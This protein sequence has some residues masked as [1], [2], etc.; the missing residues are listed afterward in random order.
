M[1]D[2]VNISANN[3]ANIPPRMERPQFLIF[4]S[5]LRLIFHD[6][7]IKKCQISHLECIHELFELLSFNI[8][9][10]KFKRTLFRDVSIRRIRVLYS[11]TLG[12]FLIEHQYIFG[13]DN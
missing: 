1:F 11:L 4:L 10:K 3:V 7:L 9:L 2:S 6:N 5:S 8:N 13:D 12:Q